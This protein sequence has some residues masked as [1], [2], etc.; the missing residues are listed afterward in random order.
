VPPPG[1]KAH[2]TLASAGA[3]A[4]H[5]AC[6]ASTKNNAHATGLTHIV[7][8]FFWEL[9]PEARTI[10]PANQWFNHERRHSELEVID[11]SFATYGCTRIGANDSASIRIEKLAPD[12]EYAKRTLPDFQFFDMFVLAK[13]IEGG[14][15]RFGLA[16]AV[17]GLP[18][19]GW[20]AS[21]VEI[22]PINGHACTC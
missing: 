19:G 1:A 12:V 16:V 4:P 3:T 13:D 11:S 20:P 2:W 15:T 7:I 8:S 22:T 14:E 10:S 9:L 21:F 17:D 5:A 18:L 6:A